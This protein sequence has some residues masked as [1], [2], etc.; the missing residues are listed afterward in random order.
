VDQLNVIVHELLV[1]TVDAMRPNASI[2]AGCGHID[3]FPWSVWVWR[4]VVAVGLWVICVAGWS[5]H[6]VRAVSLAI[7]T[8]V[9]R[10]VLG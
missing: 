4:L 3:V 10:A 1:M 9:T 6:H 7:M 8:Q 5:S 2:L